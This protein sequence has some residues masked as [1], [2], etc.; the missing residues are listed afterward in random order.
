MR[1]LSLFGSLFLLNG[2]S[3]SL[4]FR[5]SHFAVPVTGEQPW[6]G[7]I[8][9]AGTPTTKVTV[10]DN[11]SS[12]PPDR[13]EVKIN[14]A[15]DVTEV[16]L[17]G[18][19]GVDASLS[20][21]RSVDVFVDSN[22]F[23]LRWQFLNHDAKADAWVSAVHAS[24]GEMKSTTSNNAD[25]AVSKIK[26]SQGGLSVGYKFAAFVP[27]VSYIYETHDV[28]T[29]VTNSLGAFGPYDDKGTHQYVS[30]G[31]SSYR[32][33]LMGAIEY[34]LIDINWDRAKN[35]KQNSVAAKLGF[36]W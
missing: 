14:D 17:V 23:G 10:V 32:R 27:Y 9:V 5:A 28:S 16:L 19:V 35:E 11:I 1:L 15:L 13:S 26:T 12:N 31:L 25:E 30:V 33:G 18:Y 24:Y 21:L 3:H 29:E 20:V 7:H 34:S 22:L 36:A 2:C 6:N 4:R 8:A